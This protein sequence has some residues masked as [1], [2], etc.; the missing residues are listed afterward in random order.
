M[1]SPRILICFLLFNL[2]L[3]S[4][5]TSAQEPKTKNETYTI[6]NKMPHYV[7]GDQALLKFIKSNLIYPKKALEEKTEGIVFVH[8]I[9]SKK[10][11]IADP[12]ILVSINSLL[13]QEALRIVK[14]M[15]RWEPAQEQNK[16]VAV[17]FNLPIRFKI[18]SLNKKTE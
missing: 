10:G 18:D 12:K 2:L 5:L 1:S 14:K 6:A 17:G 4:Q 13:D 9:I 16:K 3:S 15:P 11:K 8:F 7:G